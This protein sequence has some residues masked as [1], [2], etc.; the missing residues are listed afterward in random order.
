MIFTM[1][2]IAQRPRLF[3][4]IVGENLLT[5]PFAPF[6]RPISRMFSLLIWLTVLLVYVGR[7]GSLLAL[8]YA[9]R[10]TAEPHCLGARFER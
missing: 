5:T 10:N 8:K 4:G 3:L 2:F 9:P 1:S 7:H 6:E